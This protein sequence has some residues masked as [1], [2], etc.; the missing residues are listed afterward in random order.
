MPHQQCDPDFG[1]L[2][3]AQGLSVPC[4][5]LFD[6][7]AAFAEE[8]RSLSSLGIARAGAGRSQVGVLPIRGH[9]LPH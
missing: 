5:H 4:L 7:E 2:V 9:R 8:S 6:I 3:E 1:I